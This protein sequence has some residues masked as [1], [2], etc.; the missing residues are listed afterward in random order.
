MGPFILTLF[1]AVALSANCTV[2]NGHLSC[3]ELNL[4]VAGYGINS[5][6]MVI[7]RCDKL[8]RPSSR[9]C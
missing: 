8:G 6:D 4:V 7:K 9:A 2:E 3:P 5:V 1:F